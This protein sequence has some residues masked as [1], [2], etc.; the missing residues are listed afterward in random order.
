MS[1]LWGLLIAMAIIGLVAGFVIWVVSKLGLGLAV[2]SFGRAFVA[3]IVIALVGGIITWLLSLAGVQDSDG[4]IGGIVHLLITA[5]VL[6]ISD[7]LLPGL[8]VKG[9]TGAIVA[10]LAIGA[11]YWL[12]GLL[13]GLA[14]N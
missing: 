5:V 9:F 4:L 3:A 2:D 12:G 14:L 13:L 6:L 11:F 8:N 10:A 7:R 1:T